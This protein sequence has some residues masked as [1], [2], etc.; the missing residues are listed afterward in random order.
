MAKKDKG[1]LTGTPVTY[2]VPS[3]AGG[4]V[5]ETFIPWTL[6]KRG[7]KKEVITP[8]DA[9]EQFQE[10]AKR[11]RQERKAAQDSA[12]IKA[13]GLAHYWQSLLDAGKVATP[14]DI[15]REEELDVTRV[16]LLLRLTLLA[17]DLVEKI[18]LGEQ[19]DNVTLE[20]FTRS[21][22]PQCWEA[23]RAMVKRA[24]GMVPHPP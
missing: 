15:A 8:L 11:E 2:P 14:A 16:R 20:F 7:V 10:E 24:S 6:V 9:P 23:Q 19:T 5:L 3:P 1:V 22:L 18:A 4:V 17:P 12:L 13:L 21:L